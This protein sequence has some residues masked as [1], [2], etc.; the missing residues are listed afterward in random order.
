MICFGG[1]EGSVS[2]VFIE[3]VGLYL[4]VGVG[5]GVIFGDRVEVG[6]ICVCCFGNFCIV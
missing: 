5:E 1:W 3:C 6:V 2:C 4:R